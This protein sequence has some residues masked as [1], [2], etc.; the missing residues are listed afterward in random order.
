MTFSLGTRKDDEDCAA[1]SKKE[2]RSVIKTLELAASELREAI[3]VAAASSP[4]VA[5]VSPRRQTVVE[6]ATQ[7]SDTLTM[8]NG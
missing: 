1:A 7:V 6:L 3:E 4:A 2:L 5:L 8:R